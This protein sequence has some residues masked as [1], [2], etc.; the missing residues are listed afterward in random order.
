MK[1]STLFIVAVWILVCTAPSFADEIVKPDL[2]L[3]RMPANLGKNFLK[4]FTKQNLSTLYT[5]AVATGISSTFDDELHEYFAQRNVEATWAE[6]CSTLG[7]PYVLA[8]VVTTVLILGHRS[9]DERFHAFSYALAQ[10]YILNF[11]LTQAIKYATS[12]DRPDHSNNYSFPSGHASDTFMI[13]TVVNRYYGKKAGAIAY[14]VAS[15]FSASRLKKDRHWLSDVVGGAA[16]GYIVGRDVSLNTGGTRDSAQFEFYPAFAPGKK[17][18][19]LN[20]NIRW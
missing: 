15:L 20:V 1:R 17:E 9:S 10:G 4:I 6:V 11:G 5:G 2:S 18:F 13:A 14:G 3:K 7:K 16:L 8:P 12:R 19:G